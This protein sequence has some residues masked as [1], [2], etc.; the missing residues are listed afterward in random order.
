MFIVGL[1]WD[2]GTW[3]MSGLVFMPD[4]T[5]DT[6]FHM[7]LPA[8]WPT[9]SNKVSFSFSFQHSIPLLR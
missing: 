9:S 8:P 3:K 6:F 4:V 7:M 1:F 5:D 2:D